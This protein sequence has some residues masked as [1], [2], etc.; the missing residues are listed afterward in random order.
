MRFKGTRVDIAE[1]NIRGGTT[2]P[3]MAFRVRFTSADGVV[4]AETRHEIL[5]G[6]NQELYDAAR[7]LHAALVQWATR[8]HFD[9]A[10]EGTSRKGNVARGISEALNNAASP[11][12]LEKQ[13]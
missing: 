10:G 8:T 9:D 12:D 6:E 2:A 1:I 3:I 7:H 5:A 13:G 4:H 11:D